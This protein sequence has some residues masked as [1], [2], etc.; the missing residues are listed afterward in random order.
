MHPEPTPPLR[1]ASGPLAQVAAAVVIFLAASL[2]GSL[3]ASQASAQGIAVGELQFEVLTSC[4]GETGRIDVDITNTTEV[5]AEFEVTVGTVP[6]RSITI[7][8]GLVG[9]VTV[10][11]RPSGPLTVRVA[12]PATV[13]EVRT[14]QVQVACAPDR[15]EFDAETSCLAGRGRVDFWIGTPV[16]PGEIVPAV[17]VNWVL[18]L[19]ATDPSTGAERPNPI[20]REI[21]LPAGHGPTRVSVTGRSDGSYI[22]RGSVSIGVP[23]GDETTYET[24]V[25]VDCF[26]EPSSFV[27]NSC[28]AGN[29]RIDIFLNNE[30]GEVGAYEVM[31]SGLD[32]RTIT[33]Q[34]QRTGRVTVTGRADG[35]FEVIAVRN[36]VVELAEQVEVICDVD[37]TRITVLN[38]DFPDFG[39]PLGPMAGVDVE[40]Q[41]LVTDA[42]FVTTTDAN[43]Q[44]FID[45]PSSQ[46]RFVV[47]ADTV[48]PLCSYSSVETQTVA[49]EFTDVVLETWVV[50]S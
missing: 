12:S 31:V 1:S 10:T 49:G 36:G 48:D 40:I 39:F 9:R 30:N 14:E 3:A 22:A 45:L 5:V 41:D 34:P 43:G 15:G 4:I 17:Q 2:A 7:G 44:A 6:P 24:V 16:E 35:F 29:G 20:I 8:Q 11:G 42:R 33:L 37:G 50:C 46:Y 47:S 19:H 26:D 32:A 18:S 25:A 27:A 21:E 38:N 28:L 23:V 13:P